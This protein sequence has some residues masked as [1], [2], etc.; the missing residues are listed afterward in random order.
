[1]LQREQ[2]A[3]SA[4]EEANRAKDEFLAMLGHEL[5]NPLSPIL[6][7]L[8]LMQMRGSDSFRRER[9]II[10]RQV[11]HLVNLVDD[12]LDVSRITRGKIQLKLEPLELSTVVLKAIEMAS[13]IIEQR[14]H[15]LTAVVP[16][17]GLQIEADPMRLSQVIC[18]LLT[19]A[20]KYT[21][22]GGNISIRADRD[23]GYIALRVRDNGIGISSA[24]LPRVFELFS[25][26]TRAL[27]RAQGGLGIG[28]TIVKSLVELHGGS[29]HAYSEG[30]GKGSEFV[31]R[32]PAEP[33]QGASRATVATPRRAELIDHLGTPRRILIV[34]DNQDAAEVLGDALQEAGYSTHVA[35][36]APA[37]LEM[38]GAFSPDI[39]LIDIG[40]PVMDG[41]ELA[42]RL[43]ANPALASVR[44]IAITGYGQE[45]DRQRAL[46]AGFDDHLVKPI[47]LD[48]LQAML[49]QHA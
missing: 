45:S 1:M 22:P 47:D 49:R 39:M 4:A 30:I 11:H 21:E 16:P 25:Q 34:D 27:D 9:D 36:D 33:T 46:E 3:R 37:T 31:I 41:Y 10:E 2:E 38:V 8:N 19:N 5:R 40:L 32:L 28:L 13:P 7:S 18:N 20:A 35:F 14:M 42:R 6:T 12:L 48:R 43:R 24:L 44:L 15:H 17:V 29:V 23:D 26:G